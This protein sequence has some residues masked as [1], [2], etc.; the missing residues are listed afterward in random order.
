MSG[1]GAPAD[2]ALPIIASYRVFLDKDYSWLLPFDEFAFI[3]FATSM[4]QL[5][6]QILNSAEDSREYGRRARYAVTRTCGSKCIYPH[7]LI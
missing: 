2:L 3:V 7:N 1:F 4:G 6:E 5:L